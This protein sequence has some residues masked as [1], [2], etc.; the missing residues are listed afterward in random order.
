LIIKETDFGAPP[1]EFFTGLQDRAGSFLLDSGLPA[2]GLGAWSFAG[3]DPFL[4]FRAKGNDITFT[5]NGLAE[6]H[7]GDPL[8]ELRSLLQRFRCVSAPG[9]PFSGG[10]VGYF[11]YELCGLL[12]R[13]PRAT[14]GIL[15]IPDIEFGFY[16][17]ILAFD[18]GA[19]RSFIVAN[20]VAGRDADAIVRS[21]E[22]TVREALQSKA[23]GD[24]SPL[25][26]AGQA[27]ALPRSNFSKAGYLAAIARIKDYI[28]AG[29]VY[30]VNLSQ[31]FDAP[32]PCHPY[33]LYRRLR[34]LSP[35]PFAAYLNCGTLQVAGSSPER[36][37]RIR[38]GR[39][40]TRPI[41][42]TR[43]R[44]ALPADDARLGNELLASEKD[45]AELLMIVDVE[46]NDLG[47]ICEVGSIRVDDIFRLETHPTVHHLVAAVSGTIRSGCDAF[48][49]IRSLFP[50]GSITGAPKIRAMQIIDEIET[51]PR[52][53]YTGAVG[54]LGF[55]GNCDLNVAIRTIYCVGDRAYF[56]AG[57]GIVWDSDPEAEYQE[58]L[59]K[60]RAM[61]AALTES[62]TGLRPVI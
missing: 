25:R 6:T 47:R 51:C 28:R 44:G 27:P 42:G 15:P 30:Q 35:A 49:C 9:L 53:L 43:P 17:G 55:D 1:E 38:D 37:L 40:E 57:G 45:R 61:R 29:D 5:R 21:M 56:H 32:L 3:F 23:G 33:S 24:P 31:R 13:I 4:V 34:K 8:A 39:I 18:H 60:A 19:G 7:R 48:D 46:R 41:K 14:A 20:P 10:A 36:F 50:G 2:G 26:S 22:G 62:G 52:H 54:Y 11:S 58:T 59:D 12:E 16:D